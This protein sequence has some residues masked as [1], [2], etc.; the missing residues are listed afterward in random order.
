MND[1]TKESFTD[2][3]HKTAKANHYFDQ[4]SFEHAKKSYIGAK[5]LALRLFENSDQ[6]ERAVAALVVSYHNLSNLYQ[7]L[8]QPKRAYSELDE[9]DA[10]LAN[11]L[12]SGL[13]S[14]D[15]K[16]A[17]RHGIDRTRAELFSFIKKNKI[18]SAVDNV[19]DRA[20]FN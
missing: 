16:I 5:N 6:P 13:S 1:T 2:W 3:E 14:V 8:N 15:V 18:T 7:Q 10:Y 19:F 20:K 17:V 11:C 4:E 12:K 9:V